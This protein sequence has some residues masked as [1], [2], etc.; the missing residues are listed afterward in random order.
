MLVEYWVSRRSAGVSGAR[1]RLLLLH[2]NVVSFA[3]R[4][5]GLVVLLH[6]LQK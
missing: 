4:L 3:S 1:K 6:A 5:R 2:V